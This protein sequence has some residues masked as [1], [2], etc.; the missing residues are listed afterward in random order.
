[1]ENKTSQ[2]KA[3]LNKKVLNL[4]LEKKTFNIIANICR[5][6]KISKEVQQFLSSRPDER[7]SYQL[8]TVSLTCWQILLYYTVIEGK[9]VLFIIVK[10]DKC[11]SQ[12]T[13]VD[14]S[15]FQEPDQL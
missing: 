2:F 10:A 9:K 3:L 1:M 7:T 4:T 8:Q 12:M 6:V 11:G 14:V 15:L 13:C 5:Q